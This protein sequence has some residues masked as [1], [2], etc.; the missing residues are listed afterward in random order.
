MIYIKHILGWFCP[1]DTRSC[2]LAYE[3]KIIEINFREDSKMTFEHDDTYDCGV[4][5]KV[6]GVGGG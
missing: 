6:I 5:I 2:A 1:L 3:I 4:N